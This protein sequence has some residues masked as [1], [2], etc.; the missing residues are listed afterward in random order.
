MLTSGNLPVK[1]E[2]G[3]Q[4]AV[5][6]ST[7]VG[8]SMAVGEIATFY[9]PKGQLAQVT[10]GFWVASQITLVVGVLICGYFLFK[11][12]GQMAHNETFSNTALR[13][14]RGI[15]WTV[16]GTVL[17]YGAFVLLGGNLVIRDL[18]VGTNAFDHAVSSGRMYLFVALLAVLGCVDQVF[19]QGRQNQEDVEGLV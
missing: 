6:L 3:E 1:L 14:V 9:V 12:A 13:A 17:M 4:G 5:P 2:V 15:F 18:G 16:L 8:E 11:L 7:E 19:R 10:E